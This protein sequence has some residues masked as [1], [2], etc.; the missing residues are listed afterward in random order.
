M[1]LWTNQKKI[2]IGN[3]LYYIFYLMNGNKVFCRFGY[4]FYL[5][6]TL[7]VRVNLQMFFLYLFYYNGF[8]SIRESVYL[9][10]FILCY[11]FLDSLGYWQNNNK[12]KAI[13]DINN[14]FTLKKKIF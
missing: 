3:K 13:S 9:K 12:L 10:F 14:N 6:N 4:M 5:N 1:R 8:I 7:I 11:F 2:K